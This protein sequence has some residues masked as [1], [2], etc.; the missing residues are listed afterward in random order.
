MNAG[1]PIKIPS[2]VRSASTSTRSRQSKIGDMRATLSVDQHVGRFYVSVHDT[3]LVSIFE[4]TRDLT[5]QLGRFLDREASS[6][7]QHLL[8]RFT[9]DELA[10]DVEPM[11]G[12]VGVE[13]CHDMGMM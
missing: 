10:G 5:D 9:F 6:G 8:Q 11:I 2:S 7:I 13:H 1:V 3:I 4:R 12:C